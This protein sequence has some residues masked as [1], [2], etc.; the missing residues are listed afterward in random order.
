[1]GT[2]DGERGPKDMDYRS[3]ANT[4]EDRLLQID[5][6]LARPDS[7][8]D[9]LHRERRALKVLSEVRVARPCDVPWE[10][11]Q[12]DQRVRFCDFCRKSV[13]NLSAV[14]AVEAAQLIARNEQE[15]CVQISRR[16]DGTVI[17][18]DCPQTQIRRRRRL[19]SLAAAAGATLASLG[20]VS[21]W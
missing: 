19:V 5:T 3:G 1:M 10:Q 21:L 12:G 11:M 15:L 17:T 20:A 2:P 18:G 7:E 14:T 16:A 4:P 13:Y 8:H 6:A 9:A